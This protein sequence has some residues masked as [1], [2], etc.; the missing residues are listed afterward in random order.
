MMNFP[1]DTPVG[2]LVAERPGRA[3]VLERFGIDYCC[4]GRTPLAQACAERGLDV[5]E[6]LRELASDDPRG[7]E[8]VRDDGTTDATMGQLADRIVATHHAYLRRELPR[9]AG[10]MAKVADAHANRHPELRGLHHVFG[11]LK[12]ELEHHML[13]EEK[14]LF[15]IIKQLEAATAMPRLHCG[16]VNNPILVMEHEHASAG[17]AL[18]RM[19]A[20]TGG[21]KPPGDACATYRAL[22]HGLA[23]LEMDLHRHIHKENNI[24]FPRASALEAALRGA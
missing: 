9:L 12:D 4:G 24:L 3:R 15:P 2:Q 1:S 8:P 17:S 21:F 6:V 13:K 22:L 5:V 11:E 19:R 20:L 7:L 18:Q 16:S 14:V 23:D 10:L